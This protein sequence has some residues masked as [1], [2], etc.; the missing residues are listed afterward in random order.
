MKLFFQF[1][2]LKIITY[3]CFYDIL[4]FT[5]QESNL[6][7]LPTF[8]KALYYYFQQI[9]LYKKCVLNQIFN[10]SKLLQFNIRKLVQH[11]KCCIFYQNIYFSEIR[12]FNLKFEPKF[13]ISNKSLDLG[14]CLRSRLSLVLFSD[15]SSV[16]MSRFLILNLFKK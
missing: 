13:G 5:F 2:K 8:C 6:L 3:R 12:I 4:S 7:K 14:F 16:Q 10:H 9:F 1:L 15:K 11:R